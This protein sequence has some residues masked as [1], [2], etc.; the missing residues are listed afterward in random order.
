ML[1]K[2]FLEVCN[3]DFIISCDGKILCSSVDFRLPEDCDFYLNC[4]IKYVR[5]DYHVFCKRFG[6]LNC[7]RI[8]LSL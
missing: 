7:I 6:Y 3:D 2:D 4:H 8:E 5:S 1:L